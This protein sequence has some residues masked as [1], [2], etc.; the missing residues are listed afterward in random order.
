MTIESKIAAI[1]TAVFVLFISFFQD[2]SGDLTRDYAARVTEASSLRVRATLRQG[3]D[4]PEL[5]ILIEEAEAAVRDMRTR[6]ELLS[7]AQSRLTVALFLLQIIVVTA[8]QNGATSRS[9]LSISL[10]WGCLLIGI[11]SGGWGLLQQ[12]L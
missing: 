6:L 2:K 7:T 11:A 8:H 9:R 12:A 10:Q 3:S 4:A 1:F 5:T